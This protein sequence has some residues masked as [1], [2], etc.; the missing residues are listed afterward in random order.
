MSL[1]PEAWGTPLEQ[2]VIQRLVG[3]VTGG[4]PGGQDASA[5]IALHV[6]SAA[7]FDALC[8]GA[9]VAPSVAS[10]LSLREQHYDRMI[11]A[12]VVDGVS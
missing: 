5:P 3:E 2:A 8:A 1:R 4:G 12:K 9:G 10:V 7:H 6:P 11:M